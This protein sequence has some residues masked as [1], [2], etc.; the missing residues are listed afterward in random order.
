MKA[1]IDNVT[2]LPVR[3]KDTE[4]VVS[5]VQFSAGC[6]HQRA[7]VDPALAE[8]TCADC[9]AKLNPIQFLVGLANMENS[10]KYQQESI[11]AARRALAERKKCRCTKC[12]EWTEIRRV[13]NRELKRI[14]SSSDAS[15]DA[16]EPPA[17]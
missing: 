6:R 16:S 9:S 13:G 7:I 11:A 8:L 10:W 2:R 15:A 17:P 12:G 4:K 5:V 14:A 3:L 1:P